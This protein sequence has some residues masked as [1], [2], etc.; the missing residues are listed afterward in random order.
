MSRKK[1]IS[2]ETF[3]TFFMGNK[4]L[5]I[6]LILAFIMSFSTDLFLSFDNIMNVIR[7]ISAMAII[8]VGFTALMGAGHI[9]VSVGSMMGLIGALMAMMSRDGMPILPTMMIGVGCG[10]VFGLLNGVVTVFFDIPSFIVTLATASIFRGALYIISNMVPISGLSDSFLH[11][12]QGRFGLIPVPVFIVAVVAVVGFFL[13]NNTKFGRHAIA[14]G[15]NIAAARAS[16]IKVKQTVIGVFILVGVVTAIA[17]IVMTGRV[18]SAQLSAGTGMEM[19]VI[20]AVVIGGTAMTGGN[21]N[22]IGSIVG[23]LLVGTVANVLNLTGVDP[24]YQIVSKGALILL[25]VI[26]DRV[27]AKVVTRISQ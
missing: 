14:V 27:S 26:L 21:G 2:T 3:I 4:A 16:G 20:A 7:Q 1:R 6:F 19:D 15:G 23:C 9:D 17:A 5:V 10:V 11:I 25:A 18:G 12:G 22:V 24:N 8:S 13:V